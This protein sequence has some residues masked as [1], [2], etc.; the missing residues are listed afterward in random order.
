MSQQQ[1]LFECVTSSAKR[2]FLHPSLA[3]LLVEHL[4]GLVVGKV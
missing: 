1:R 4:V 3:D 2:L